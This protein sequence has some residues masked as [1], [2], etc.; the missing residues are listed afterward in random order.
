MQPRDLELTLRSLEP[1][2][3]LSAA[4]RFA[5]AL[6]TAGHEPGRL[7]VVG[8]PDDEPWHLTAHLDQSARWQGAPSMRPV[9][10]R[11]H[12]PPG[13]PPHLSV[14]VDAVHRAERGTTILVAAASA[15]DEHLLERL[16]DAR[17]GGAALFAL[18]PGAGPLDELVHASLALPTSGVGSAAEGF[19]T[20]THVVSTVAADEPQ[21]RRPRWRPTSGSS[22]RTRCD[23]I[24]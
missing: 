13:A 23:P 9:L 16:H 12:V 5:T 3:W 24:G 14:G 4:R 20:A 8:T 15:A 2:G 17:R 7:L 19:E 10:V 1:S 6:R 18:H 21:R 22:A 11:W